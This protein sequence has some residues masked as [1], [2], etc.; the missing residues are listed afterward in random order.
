MKALTKDKHDKNTW[1]YDGKT[2]PKHVCGYDLGVYYEINRRTNK[3]IIEYY[4]DGEK[5]DEKVEEF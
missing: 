5:F 1:S 4:R 3:V 2:F